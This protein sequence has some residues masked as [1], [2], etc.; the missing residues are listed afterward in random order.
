MTGA[1]GHIL[2]G[3][4]NGVLAVTRALGD[5]A[6]KRVGVVGRPEVKAVKVVSVGGGEGGGVDGEAG[7]EGEG[8]LVCGCDGVWEV[9]GKEEVS[10][11]VWRGRRAGESVQQTA[12]RLCRLCIERG[13]SDNVT[14]VIVHLRI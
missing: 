1:G 13:S 2:M 12:A 11:E 5:V 7:G 8:L 14:V 10:E 6:M 9:M 3:R 4:V